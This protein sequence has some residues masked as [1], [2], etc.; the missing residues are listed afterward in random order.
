MN[1]AG[2]KTLVLGAVPDPGRYAY[3]AVSLLKKKGH[4]PVPVGI[5]KGEIEG[6]PIIAP[7]N[8]RGKIDTV[9]LYISPKHQDQYVDFILSAGPKRVIFNPGTENEKLKRI[10][11]RN[12]IET[13]ENCTLVMLRTGLF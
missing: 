1:S 2:K 11:E 9:T 8:F 10:L 7:E 6:L 4:M 5:R 12:G 13:V 3:K